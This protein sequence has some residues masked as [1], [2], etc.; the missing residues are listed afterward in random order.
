MRSYVA[1]SNNRPWAWCLD[2]PCLVD[3]DNPLQATATCTCRATS[4]PKSTY[5]ATSDFY[6]AAA[7]TT[8][9]I[10]SAT[11][12]DGNNIAQFWESATHTDITIT[13]LTPDA[14]K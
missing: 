11:T 13:V 4:S 14:G 8:G 10:S 5:I 3:A 2:S 1:C 6:S 12:Q 7:C 9:I